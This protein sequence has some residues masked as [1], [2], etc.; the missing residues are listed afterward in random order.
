MEAE[1]LRGMISD[2]D[3]RMEKIQRKSQEQAQRNIELCQQLETV[4]AEV[5]QQSQHISIEKNQLVSQYQSVVNKL[6][7]MQ[8][9]FKQQGASLKTYSKDASILGKANGSS[10]DASYVMR[11]QAQLCKA[12]HS[13]GITDHQME[14][15]TK[16]TDL[17]VKYQKETL[18]QCREERTSTELNLMNQLIEKDNER[19]SIEESYQAK[20]DVIAK[21][22]EALER[23]MEESGHDLEDDD[24]EGNTA[25]E[26]DEEDVEEKEM[27]QEL[28]QLLT[29]RRSE[30]ERLE[31]AI[32][33]QE[34]LIAELEEQVA[35]MVNSPGIV[36]RK[37]PDELIPNT[38]RSTTPT[39]TNDN[40]TNNNEHEEKQEKEEEEQEEVEEENEQVEEEENE[41]VE[42]EENE[43][44]EEDD[45]DAVTQ[46]DEVSQTQ[47]S[48]PPVVT[49]GEEDETPTTLSAQQDEPDVVPEVT[50]NEIMYDDND[51][52]D[53]KT[54]VDT[55]DDSIEKT[56][57]DDEE[58]DH[59]SVD[60][61][62]QDNQ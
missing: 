12:M 53:N 36:Q 27:K 46:S 44:R 58:E 43:Q 39:M 33:E 25:D 62:P 21:E 2:R 38:Q 30:I 28:M 11:M 55:I 4:A 18:V 26:D 20:L 9:D 22:R 40:T 15:A 17:I 13:L 45:D 37:K 51:M 24:D 59:D 23:Q 48:T 47:Q 41:Q 5:Q 57:V 19:R 1:L 14:L 31:I 7:Q 29:E 42:E 32:E 35:D 60:A 6:E 52:N 54:S 56:E 10:G 3:L 34:D 16:H 8:R 49:A 50:D 61:T